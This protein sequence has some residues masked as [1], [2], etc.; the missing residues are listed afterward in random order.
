[1]KKEKLEIILD[2]YQYE[3]GDDCRCL[4]YGTTT[5]V[6]GK[7]LPIHNDDTATIVK[8]IL[9]HL[10]YEVKVICQESGETYCEV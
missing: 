4:N 6:N 2:D 9:E 1:M 10:G 3:C 8:Q 5:T 7:E